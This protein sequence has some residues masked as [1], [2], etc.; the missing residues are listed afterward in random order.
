MNVRTIE[1]EE[2]AEKIQIGYLVHM[3]EGGEKEMG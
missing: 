2:Q 3:S 1:Q